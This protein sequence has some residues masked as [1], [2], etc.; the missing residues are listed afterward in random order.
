[1]TV[2]VR[3]QLLSFSVKDT[4]RE[5]QSSINWPECESIPPWLRCCR[6]C[7]AVIVCQHAVCSVVSR[8]EQRAQS[9]IDPTSCRLRCA[10]VR[11]ASAVVDHRGRR[12]TGPTSRT[13]S[14]YRTSPTGNRATIAAPLSTAV[15]EF[16]DKQQGRASVDRTMLLS[17][18]SRCVERWQ[19]VNGRARDCD[20]L[21]DNIPTSSSSD[22]WSRTCVPRTYAPA[23]IDFL[24]D[25]FKQ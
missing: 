19:S 2:I 22:I 1:M 13:W 11:D 9:G 8:H 21:S 4:A 15:A 3:H 5:R 18:Q 14:R 6:D 10:S 23:E 25:F 24:A 12:R 20:C 7:H 17:S 16:I